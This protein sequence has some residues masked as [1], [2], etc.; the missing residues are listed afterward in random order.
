M[1]DINEQ[2]EKEHLNNLKSY[3]VEVQQEYLSAIDDIFRTVALYRFLPEVFKLS[4][5]PTL[6]KQIEER[7]D[8]FRRRVQAIISRGIEKEFKL[9][10]TKNSDL[11]LQKLEGIS[12][13]PT[14]PDKVADF[15]NAPKRN[16]RL[17]D[18]V[19]KLHGQ[20]YEEIEMNLYAGISEG[21]AAARMA[22]DMKQFLKEPDKLFRRVRDAKGRL[23]LSGPARK[24]QPG[25]GIYKSSYKNA[26]RL[27]ATETNAAYRTADQTRW[28]NT[29]FVLGYE[30][31]L[32]KNHKTFDICDH[33]AAVYPVD[34]V[35]QHWHPF[36]ICYC[37]PLLPSKEEYAKY[38][39]A[40]L[41]G[42]EAG[43]EFK[44]KITDVPDQF[45]YYLADNMEKMEGRKRLP[46]WVTTNRKFT[47]AD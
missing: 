21:K 12:L 24:Y 26:L 43:Y 40:I 32:S 19:W 41:K 42:E 30:V 34:F 8:M 46:D 20:F 15:I 37:V 7:L 47:K 9:S 14:P 28:S 33:L 36:C 23:V 13:P 5:Y 10:D 39:D 27:V 6:K 4:K 3:Q 45:K 25:Q 29:P 2:Y 17:S 18:R 31:R 16:L 35:W 38:Q 22:T 11:I 1:P 44:N